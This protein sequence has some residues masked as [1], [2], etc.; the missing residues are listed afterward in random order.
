MG[1]S[2]VVSVFML[3]QIANLRAN[4]TL[5]IFKSV[6]VIIIY[7]MLVF[8][9]Q[10]VSLVIYSFT[11]GNQRRKSAVK[12]TAMI[13]LLIVI[14]YIVYGMIN[15]GTEVIQEF[16]SLLFQSQDGFWECLSAF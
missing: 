9:S 3:F 10:M 7:M 6:Y 13:L 15:R 11:N 4:F 8:I 1:R 2:I 12:Y 16:L 5:S 14:A